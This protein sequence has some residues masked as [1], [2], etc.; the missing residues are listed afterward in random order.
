M[1]CT[2]LFGQIKL[3]FNGIFYPQGNAILGE[4]QNKIR[5]FFYN[6]YI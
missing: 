5:W 6:T 4:F 2:I 3:G 1:E